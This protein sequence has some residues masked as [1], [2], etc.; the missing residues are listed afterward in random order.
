MALRGLDH[1]TVRCMDIERSRAFYAEAL[2]LRDGERPAVNIPGAWLYLGDRPVVHLF[3]GRQDDGAKTTGGFD[4]VAFDADDLPGVRARLERLG[5][6]F[7]ESGIPDMRLHQVFLH[8]PDGV[9]I[10]INFRG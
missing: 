2:G 9:M 4:H 7:R 6:P 3:G 10:E 8:D 1:V 5:V